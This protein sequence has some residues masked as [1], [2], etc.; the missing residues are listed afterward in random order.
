MNREIE[1]RSVHMHDVQEYDLIVAFILVP[2]VSYNSPQMHLYG[3][4]HYSID[5]VDKSAALKVS[6][7]I[8]TGHK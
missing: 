8:I 2:T 5:Y 1:Q 4:T 6:L 7:Q 3:R